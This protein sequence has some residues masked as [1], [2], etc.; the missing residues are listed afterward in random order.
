MCLKSRSRNQT[1]VLHIHE[2]P[3]ECDDDGAY[4]TYTYLDRDTTLV[5]IVLAVLEVPS[6]VGELRKK[7]GVW[8]LL[9]VVSVHR[10]DLASKRSERFHVNDLVMVPT[11][12]FG[13]NYT[14]MTE[15]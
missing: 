11:C 4:A 13:H 14:F 7:H 10:A 1:Y 9:Q 2:D 12:P 5:C 6:I 3:A 8:A 15:L